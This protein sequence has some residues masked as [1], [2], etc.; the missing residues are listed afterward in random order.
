MQQHK[1]SE[2]IVIAPAGMGKAVEWAEERLMLFLEA[3][4]PDYQFRVEP[5]GPFADEWDFGII[6]IMNR[7]PGPGD[8]P[9]RSDVTYMCRLEPDVIPEIMRVLQS[10]DPAASTTH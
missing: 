7:M 4:F 6:P 8:M 1:V 10:F 3:H 2:F 9:E 5:F